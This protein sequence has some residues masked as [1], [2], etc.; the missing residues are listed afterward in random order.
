[1][2]A[3]HALLLLAAVAAVGAHLDLGFR[4][5]MNTA[6]SNSIRTRLTDVQTDTLA[7]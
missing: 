4:A 1:V 2:R 3:P 6:K 7:R 5:S